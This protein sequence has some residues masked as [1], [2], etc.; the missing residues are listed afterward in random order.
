MAFEAIY[1]ADMLIAPVILVSV[2]GIR[3]FLLKIRNRKYDKNIT[4][5]SEGDEYDF[6]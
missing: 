2:L 5:N 6:N 1:V 4:V 3:I